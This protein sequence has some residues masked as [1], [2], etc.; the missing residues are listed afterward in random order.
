MVLAGCG[1]LLALVVMSLPGYSTELENP[2]PL[3]GGPVFEPASAEFE[4][5]VSRFR[6]RL[7]AETEL[8]QVSR[9]PFIFPNKTLPV[10]Q[11]SSPDSS[12]GAEFEPSVRSVS[13]LFELIGIAENVDQQSDV[14]T[15]T[16]VIADSVGLYLLQ[17]GDQL[18]STF[19]VRRIG[20][21]TVDLEGSS[22]GRSLRLTLK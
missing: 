7:K 19:E 22:D 15:R 6:E 9:N 20:K 21:S 1:F 5:Q 14:I 11:M 4:D 10:S 13:P 2:L 18:G 3:P 8:H 16:A 17:E 12:P